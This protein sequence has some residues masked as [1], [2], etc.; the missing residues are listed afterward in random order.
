MIG[1]LCLCTLQADARERLQITA[2]KDESYVPQIISVRGTVSLRMG[3]VLVILARHAEFGWWHQ[4]Q[5]QM[6]GPFVFDSVH[7]GNPREARGTRFSIAAFIVTSEVA[8]QMRSYRSYTG[9]PA[10]PQKTLTI[11]R[12]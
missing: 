5:T 7:I 2:P 8:E 1:I 4:G 9:V 12:Q 11:Y 6:S 10:S 3:E